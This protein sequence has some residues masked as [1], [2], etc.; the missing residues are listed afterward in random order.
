M[1]NKKIGKSI[2]WRGIIGISIFFFM[3][4]WSC[5]YGWN[6]NPVES[7][8]Q[9]L[10]G[11][12]SMDGGYFAGQLTVGA[13]VPLYLYSLVYLRKEFTIYHVVRYVTREKLWWKEVAAICRWALVYVVLFVLT[14]WIGLFF[15]VSKKLMLES[16]ILL[17]TFKY[18]MLLFFFY[19]FVGILFVYLDFFFKKEWGAVL[20]T[21]LLL[22]LLFFCVRDEKI[23]VWTPI[24]CLQYINVEIYHIGSAATKFF[25]YG[26]I[27]CFDIVMFIGGFYLYPK[28][29]YY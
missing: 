15:T 18:G 13:F 25:A 26:S 8:I 10:Y 2:F 17:H 24:N 11:R 22:I 4:W 21:V 29:E 3:V 14:D 20:V 5:E 6:D 12:Q 19:I 16:N 28:K 7:E 23:T 1:G 9:N 27:I